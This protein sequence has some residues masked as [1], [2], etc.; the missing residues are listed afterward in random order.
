MYFMKQ[1][2]VYL[3]TYTGTLMPRYYIGSTSRKKIEEGYIGTVISK[4]WKNVFKK[5]AR[6]HRELF[7]VQILSEHETRRGALKHEL[8]EQ[9]K[10]DDVKSE[11]Y[12]NMSFAKVNGFFWYEWTRATND[13]RAKTKA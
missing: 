2:V 7:T 13:S 1:Y 6:D 4:K 12:I 5:E 8:E 10:R 11:E 9:L 3:T